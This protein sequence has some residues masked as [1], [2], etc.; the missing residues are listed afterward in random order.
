MRKR[1]LLLDD[2]PI[3]LRTVSRTLGQEFDVNTYL[4]GRLALEA[5][6]QQSFD[7]VVSDMDIGDMT[8]VE[9]YREAVKVRPEL[10]QRFVFHTG[11]P[12]PETNVP[13]IRKSSDTTVLRDRV[14]ALVS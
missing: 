2:D 14:R 9:F 8:G 3:I 1:V 6:R 5:L 13:V 12:V 7:A 10:S 4:Q 11:S